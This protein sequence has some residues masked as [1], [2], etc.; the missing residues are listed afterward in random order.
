[1]KRINLILM[2]L[3]I[4]L[5][6]CICFSFALNGNV[7]FVAKAATPESTLKL[8]SRDG[9]NTVY[10]SILNAKENEVRAT[11]PKKLLAAIKKTGIEKL[12]ITITKL[13]QAGEASTVY[14]LQASES[15]DLIGKILVI[16]LLSG[17]TDVSGA[18]Y[19]AGALQEGSYEL[20]ITAGTATV[21]GV[22]D[23][24][25]PAVVVG[26][27]TPGGGECQGGTNQLTSLD[28]SDLVNLYIFG[29][30]GN[31]TNPSSSA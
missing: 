26:N 27:V 18:T 28:A 15:V 3:A 31:P 25:P 7:S 10:G 20:A 13:A 12:S 2:A 17:L 11:V 24:K 23:Y 4:I 6:S 14:N 9:S 29:F 1:M 22:F 16:N 21:K 19:T 8:K 30:D 5:T